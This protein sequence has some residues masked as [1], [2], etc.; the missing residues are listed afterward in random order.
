MHDYALTHLSDAVLLR[1]LM[2]LVARDRTTTAALLAHIAEVDSRRLYAP[3]GYSSMHAYCVDELR[4]SEDAAYK[5]IRAARAARQFPVLFGAIADGRLHL[6]AVY[7]LAPHLTPVNV[8]ELIEM[9]THRQKSEI[10]ELLAQ[11]FA[12]P[13]PLGRVHAMPTILAPPIALSA[14]PQTE[15]DPSTVAQLAPGP[16]EGTQVQC[17]PQNYERFLVQLTIS[18]STRDKLRRAQALLSHAVPNG[19]VAEV[20][21]RALDVLIEQIE[22]RKLGAVTRQPRQRSTAGNRPTT[23]GRYVPAHV[24]RAPSGIAR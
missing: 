9:A 2:A 18:R 6:A 1:D 4:L 19:D 15:V 21:D 12:L 11:R 17:P 7:L 23:R 10:E 8:H 20:L 14:P 24:R 22:R 5:R 13:G 16:V 3:A